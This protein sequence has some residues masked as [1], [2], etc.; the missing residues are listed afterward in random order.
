M[1]TLTVALIGAGQRGDIYTTQM[2]K[3]PDKLQVI[4]VAEP[5]V[6]RREKVQKRHGIA[7]DMCFETG[8]ELLQRPKLADIV[9]ICTQ[10]NQH[11]HMAMQAI[12]QG[13]DIL[14]EKPVAPTAQECVDIAL[15]A[16]EKGVKVLVCHVL[17]YTPFFNRVKQLI[18]DGT[19]GE[20]QSVV[21]VEAVGNVHQSHS[22]VRGNWH[23][24]QDSSMMLLAK[25]RHDIDILQWLLDKPCKKV[26][27]FGSLTY[28]TEKNAPQGAPVRCIDG[29]CPIED[30]CPYNCRK[31][32]Y[33]RKDTWFRPACARD[34][35]KGEIPTD[36]EVMQALQN[37]DY[38][39][40]VFH[41]NNDNG[42]HGHICFVCNCYCGTLHVGYADRWSKRDRCLHHPDDM[43]ANY[44]FC[45]DSTPGKNPDS[46]YY[47]IL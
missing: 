42:Y 7:D 6:G 35:A 39:L 34:F 41:A 9:L 22:F 47:R 31:L 1:K 25:S 27:S 38:G 32:Y 8:E 4:A 43:R 28:F 16:N 24:E 12:A 20:V 29:G 18:L 26:Q 3:Y 46:K 5:I 15:A 33:E 11:Y 2:C 30:T 14:L 13:Y 19:V 45:R 17:R 37:T 36:Q 23:R 40:C 44:G 21:H 10:D